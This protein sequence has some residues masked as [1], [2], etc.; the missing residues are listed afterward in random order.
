MRTSKLPPFLLLPV[1]ILMAALAGCTARTTAIPV[2]AAARAGSYVAVLVRSHDPGVVSLHPNPEDERFSLSLLLESKAERRVV[3]IASGLRY[4]E[5]SQGARI[6]ADDGKLLW[7]HGNELS[8][9]DYRAHKLLRRRDLPRVIPPSTENTFTRFSESLPRG[10]RFLSPTKEFGGSQHYK[11]ALI[12]PLK[13]ADPES[14]LLTYRTQPGLKGTFVVS[15][16]AKETG[17]ALWTIETGLADVDQ[18]LPDSRELAVI[19][20]R[21]MVPDKVS[22]PFLTLIDV[23]AGTSSTHSLWVRP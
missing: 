10:D 12:T 18:I 8:A 15:R 20:R 2:G 5:A 22:E 17:K 3:A 4:S 21:P 6:L 7:F 19:G 9:Y 13:L 14:V 11:A 1:A 23:E 16:V